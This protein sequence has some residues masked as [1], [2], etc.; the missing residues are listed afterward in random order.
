[1]KSHEEIKIEF[2]R[3]WIKKA[4]NDLASAEHLNKGGELYVSGTTFHA[5]QAAEKYIKAFLVWHQIE[6]RK[7]HDI[8]ELLDLVSGI[9]HDLPEI[10]SKSVELTPYGVEYR[11]PGDYPDSTLEDAGKA[12]SVARHVRDEILSRLPEVFLN[13]EN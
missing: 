3:E 5:Q 12:L 9:D 1:M 7:T 8:Q 6:F 13:D 11:Y 2:T 10:I 4:E